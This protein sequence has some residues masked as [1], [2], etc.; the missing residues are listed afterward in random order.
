MGVVALFTLQTH[1]T[2]AFEVAHRSVDRLRAIN[3]KEIGN[4]DETL[5]PLLHE[6]DNAHEFLD[7]E[8]EKLRF[9]VAYLIEDGSHA[10][11]IQ[12]SAFPGSMFS[13]PVVACS[14]VFGV[15]VGK[16]SS[17]FHFKIFQADAAKIS[18]R[19]DEL[20][21]K[22]KDASAALVNLTNVQSVS[23][24]LQDFVGLYNNETGSFLQDILD[25]CVANTSALFL[26]EGNPKQTK[27]KFWNRNHACASIVVALNDT[28]Y[29]DLTRNFGAEISTLETYIENVEF[30]FGN[31]GSQRC[32]AKIN[33]FL[34]T[35]DSLSHLVDLA[36]RIAA[37]ETPKDAVQFTANLSNSLRDLEFTYEGI[38]D[39]FLHC[40]E[41][42]EVYQLSIPAWERAVS[43]MD[44]IDYTMTELRHLVLANQNAHNILRESILPQTDKCLMYLSANISFKELS[45]ALL[46]DEF[47]DD[48][49]ELNDVTREL[50]IKLNDNIEEIHAGLDAVAALS[51]AMS[52]NTRVL[53]PSNIENLYLLS[54]SSKM[55]D[56]KVQ[57][58]RKN[59]T[60]PSL[61]K[62]S[63]LDLM[64]EYLWTI[65]GEFHEDIDELKKVVS[66]VDALSDD[67]HILQDHLREF[68]ADIEMDTDFCL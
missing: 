8:N 31:E 44:S 23:E 61:S 28:F 37:V 11:R 12:V 16:A 62:Q 52:S 30:L 25:A 33:D 59:L 66:G 63:F 67:I 5:L 2:S 17:T 14:G 18:N 49:E 3:E 32:T 20:D 13:V 10:R 53:N 65:F 24:A 29:E 19:L 4:L 45:T 1:L 60:D 57:T 56:E 38:L 26:A 34:E 22:H 54:L 41:F 64:D 68:E 27:S 21:E 9:L 36:L 43:F 35:A 46:S 39:I 50:E 55:T 48:V 6:F 42:E 47:D 58:L 15:E 51:S 7:W 40:G